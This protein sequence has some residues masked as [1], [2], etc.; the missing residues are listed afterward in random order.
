MPQKSITLALNQ[1]KSAGIQ[2][3]LALRG[4]P[5][6]GCDTWEKIDSGFSNAIDLV[7][8]IRAN[9]GEFFCIGVAGSSVSILV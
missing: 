3:I 9:Y 5:P 7:K 2:N 8:Y 6:R 4:D 1:A